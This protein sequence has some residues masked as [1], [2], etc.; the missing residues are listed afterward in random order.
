MSWNDT[1]TN[2]QDFRTPANA[3]QS[4]CYVLTSN[5][6]LSL[7]NQGGNVLDGIRIYLGKKMVGT[8]V[9]TNIHV[10]GVVKD[11]NGNFNDYDIPVTTNDFNNRVAANTMP[12]L[13]NGKPCP[14]WCSSPNVLNT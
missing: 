6:L 5:E 11:A 3:D 10:I 1:K 7:I 4:L 12:L 13:V 2:V 14:V 8:N 9:T